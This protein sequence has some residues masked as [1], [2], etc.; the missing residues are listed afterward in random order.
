MSKKLIIA[1]QNKHK[2]E[3]FHKILSKY[4][5]EV[6]G[7]DDAGLPMDDIPENGNTFEEN[8]LIK[9]K[10]IWNMSHT[11]TLAD[12]SGLC[13]DFL[14]GAPGI[15]SSRF[16]GEN[17]TDK[18]NNE[19]LLNLLA[20]ATSDKRSACFVCVLTLILENGEEITTRG[21]CFGKI[22]T[23]ETGING[24]GYDPLF[25]PTGYNIS[26]A[27]LPP[28]EKNK[29]SHRAKAIKALVEILDQKL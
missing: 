16:S 22:Q 6:C 25:I 4:G 21:E 11:A 19:K 13:V 5:F 26:M 9:A 24:F 12:D 27:E 8:S 2:I 17:A 29:I 23:K 1:S 15:Y 7:R 18:K 3:E 20:D 14:N 10:A 28:D